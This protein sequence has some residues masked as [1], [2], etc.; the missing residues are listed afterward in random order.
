MSAQ[1]KSD[2]KCHPAW[3]RVEKY[4]LHT[5]QKWEDIA[6]KLGV[7]VSA[8]MMAKSG[9]RG[10]SSKVIYRLA[11]AEVEAGLEKPVT[12]DTTMFQLAEL[13]DRTNQPVTDF[14]TSEY[15][16]REIERLRT[17]IARSEAF[18]KESQEMLRMDKARLKE[19]EKK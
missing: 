3:A 11:Q 9:R 13:S 1:E 8:L 15:R 4:R 6:K 17:H 10:L 2:I 16:K 14:L 7:G 19:L 18:V 5:G 12:D